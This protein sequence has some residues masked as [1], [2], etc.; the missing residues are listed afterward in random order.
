M[1]IFLRDLL[2]LLSLAFQE[3]R[4]LSTKTGLPFWPSVFGTFLL[5]FIIVAISKFNKRVKTFGIGVDPSESERSAPWGN[6]TKD[7]P[8]G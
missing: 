5:L 1:T 3:G 8:M 7:E 4:Q 2:S 6:G